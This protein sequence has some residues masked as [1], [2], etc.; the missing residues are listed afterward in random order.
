MLIQIAFSAHLYLFPVQCRNKFMF[1][2]NPKQIVLVISYLYY[3]TKMLFVFRILHS[4][5]S[6]WW[7]ME[8]NLSWYQKT[9]LRPCLTPKK[10]CKDD[11]QQPILNHGNDCLLNFGKLLDFSNFGKQQ[12]SPLGIPPFQSWRLTAILHPGNCLSKS[13]N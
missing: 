7:D 11:K 9:I 5:S 10:R 3:I 12:F 2:P 1:I 6:F 8:T 4:Q 13:W